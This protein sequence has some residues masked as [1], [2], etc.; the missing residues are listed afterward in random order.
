[1]GRI[2]VGIRIVTGH[3][4]KAYQLGRGFETTQHGY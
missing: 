2:V 1:M 4:R 3:E